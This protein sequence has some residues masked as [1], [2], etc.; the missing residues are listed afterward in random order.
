M[1]LFEEFEEDLYFYSAKILKDI[2]NNLKK[3]FKKGML[4]SEDNVRALYFESMDKGLNPYTMVTFEVDK[5]RYDAYYLIVLEELLNLEDVKKSDDL[6]ITLK[7][8]VYNE[9]SDLLTTHQEDITLKDANEDFFLSQLSSVKD[10]I[11]DL[12]NED[13]DE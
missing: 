2:S 6:N 5:Y 10:E 3:W 1:K 12:A 8:K 7:I 11:E 9:N 4:S 13:E